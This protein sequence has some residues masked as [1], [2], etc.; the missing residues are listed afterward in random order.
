MDSEGHGN[1]IQNCIKNRNHNTYQRIIKPS[2][3]THNEFFLSPFIKKSS[4]V[5][6]HIIFH[7]NNTSQP[8]YDG[9]SSW[10]YSVS[11]TQSKI[12]THGNTKQNRLPL[13][14]PLQPSSQ[15]T[16]ESIKLHRK[17]MVSNTSK[18]NSNPFIVPQEKCQTK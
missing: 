14:R 6:A 15:Y 12:I 2:G 17:T 9:T 11:T 13:P 8:Q 4:H 1:Y 7:K 3:H 10:G 16:S 5:T 18:Y